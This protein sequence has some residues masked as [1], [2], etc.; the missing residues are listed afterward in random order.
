MSICHTFFNLPSDICSVSVYCL[1]AEIETFLTSSGIISLVSIFWK[2]KSN[3][4]SH[5]CLRYDFVDCRVHLNLS[6]LNTCLWCSTVWHQIIYKG[7]NLGSLKFSSTEYSF[8][9]NRF[10]SIHQGMHVSRHTP[11]ATL[12]NTCNDHFMQ[13]LMSEKHK[14]YF[15][16]L[17]FIMGES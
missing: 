6:E 1:Q 11:G 17:F 10:T 5:C 2:G 8:S 14:F 12:S 15:H 4:V 9:C 16:R 13:Y 3:V 7:G